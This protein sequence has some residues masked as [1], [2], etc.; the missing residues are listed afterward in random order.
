MNPQKKLIK[1]KQC[2]MIENIISKINNVTYV[3]ESIYIVS[4]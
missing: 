1:S 2:G 4:S 3:A